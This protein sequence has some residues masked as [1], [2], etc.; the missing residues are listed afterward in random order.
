[1]ANTVPF[2]ATIRPRGLG[3]RVSVRVPAVPSSGKRKAGL[4][5][6][7]KPLVPAVSMTSRW[8][9]RSP[10]AL[11]VKSRVTGTAMAGI[12]GGTS[13]SDGDADPAPAADADATGET[14]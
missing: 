2:A 4:Q 7:T 12:E 8:S 14:D 6:T 5:R 13:L 10:K 11:V 3:V 1:M 9:G